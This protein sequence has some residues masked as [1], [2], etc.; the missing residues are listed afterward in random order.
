MNF[1]AWYWWNTKTRVQSNHSLGNFGKLHTKGHDKTTLR[2]L[3][4]THSNERRGI[5]NILMILILKQN[6]PHISLNYCVVFSNK[7]NV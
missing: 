4:L 6:V 7:R 1:I 2:S 5:L 3:D